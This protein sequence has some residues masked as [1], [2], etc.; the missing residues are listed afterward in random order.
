MTSVEAYLQVGVKMVEGEQDLVLSVIGAKTDQGTL[1][2]CGGEEGDV[3]FAAVNQVAVGRHF[4][5]TLEVGCGKHYLNLR[6]DEGVAPSTTSPRL[7]K[8]VV[9]IGC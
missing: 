2:W 9:R 5:G 3:V 1:Q 4:E 8:A 7:T 6:E